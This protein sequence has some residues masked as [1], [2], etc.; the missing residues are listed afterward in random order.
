MGRLDSINHAIARLVDPAG[1]E[2]AFA[3]AVSVGNKAV[4]VPHSCDLPQTQA[5]APRCPV[6]LDQDLSST[7][8]SV[9]RIEVLL[10]L[11]FS[12]LVLLALP[13]LGFAQATASTQNSSAPLTLTLQDALQRARQNTPEYRSAITDFGSGARRPRTGSGDASARR[14]LQHVLHLHAGNGN[15]P[16]ELPDQ[17]CR[18]SHLPLHRQ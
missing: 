10:R 11:A 4:H 18:L 16:S 14:Q 13:R 5:R 9:S 15:A 3:E 17:H 7:R 2:F 8:T 1:R 12:I 6:N